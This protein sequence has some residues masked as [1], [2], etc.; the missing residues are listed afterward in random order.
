MSNTRLALPE[1]QGPLCQLL[2]NLSGNEPTL[3]LTALKRFLRKENPWLVFFQRDLRKEE[4]WELLEGQDEPEPIVVSRFE[5]VP[6]LK[7][8]EP[9]IGGEELVR[10]AREELRA[11][12]GQRQAEH[13]LAH[14]GQIPE[15]FRKYYLVF[16]RTVWRV[17]DGRRSVPCLCW[18]G[19]Q[20]V[21]RFYWL[22]RSFDDDYRLVRPRD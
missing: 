19:G 22:D 20:W 14:Q 1:V 12:F 10:R 11:N 15:E 6:F 21:L 2:G 4:G 17:R 3:W 13:F 9:Y 18:G 7:D 5:L 8:G 16:T